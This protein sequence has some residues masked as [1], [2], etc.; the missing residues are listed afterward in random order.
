VGTP[1]LEAPRFPLLN[2]QEQQGQTT[3]QQSKGT[4]N[5]G[6]KTRRSESLGSTG[7][8][9]ENCPTKDQPMAA[10]GFFLFIRAR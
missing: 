8:A 7:G 10:D 1:E 5:K 2:S 6:I 9:P 3:D 4:D